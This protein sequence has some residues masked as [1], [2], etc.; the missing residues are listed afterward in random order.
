MQT[1]VG[2][3][4]DVFFPNQVAKEKIREKYNIGDAFLFGSASRFHYSKGLIEVIKALPREGNWKYLMMGWG[5]DDEVERI[6]EEIKEDRS[7]R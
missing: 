1:Q 3:D 2:V 4:P 7:G 6:K 5:R